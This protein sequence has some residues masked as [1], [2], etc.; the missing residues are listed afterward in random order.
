MPFTQDHLNTHVVQ[1]FLA[2]NV[3]LPSVGALQ[4]RNPSNYDKPITTVVVTRNCK[5]TNI[6]RRK[7]PPSI[8][9]SILAQTVRVQGTTARS[10]TP[11]TVVVGSSEIKSWIDAPP[12]R[13]TR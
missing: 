10:S 4:E 11:D 8:L 3:S 13:E 5:G 7:Q 9:I 12:L 2:D 6:T 1:R